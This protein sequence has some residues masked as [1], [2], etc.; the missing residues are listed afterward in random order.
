MEMRVIEFMKGSVLFDKKSIE[1]RY[2]SLSYKRLEKELTRYR[3]F[4]IENLSKSAET[5]ERELSVLVEGF[6]F[7]R[8]DYAFLSQSALYVDQVV[9]DDPLFVLTKT[10]SKQDIVVSE[11]LGFSTDDRPDRARIA[12]TAGY[13]NKMK[14]AIKTGFLRFSPISYLHEPPQDVPLRASENL[15]F[16]V[17][18]VKVLEFFHKNASIKLLKKT[19]KGWAITGEELEQL[20][21]AIAITFGDSAAPHAIYF[22]LQTKI[23]SYDE[24]TGQVKFAQYLPDTLPEPQLFQ[25]WI[26]QSTN[27]AGK[28]IFDQV[29]NETD[30]ARQNGAIYLTRSTFIAE[31]LAQQLKL[32]Q[33]FTT[34]IVN[35]TFNLNLPVLKDVPLD[36]ILEIRQKEGEAFKNFRTDLQKKLR[37]LRQMTDQEKLRSEMENLSHE[38]VE[39]QIHEIDRKIKT[40]KRKMIPDAFIFVFGLTAV[41]QANGLGIPALLYSIDKGYRTYSDYITTVKENPAFFLWKLKDEI[42]KSD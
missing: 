27:Q 22:L 1:S 41:I 6:N 29:L 21:R 39:V 40:I 37:G 34:D 36:T 24:N 15:F 3:E 26:T 12:Q 2:R 16:E 8:T 23:L 25:N 33:D 5:K 7:R 4:C 38:L 18:P 19:E 35:L 14:K 42:R 30:L 10:K 17:L 32:E 31:L 11:H 28:R 9:L 13:L 20:G